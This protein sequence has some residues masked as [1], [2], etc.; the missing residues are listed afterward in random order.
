MAQDASKANMFATKR[1]YES[2]NAL[3]IVQMLN[4]VP[5]LISIYVRCGSD[6]Y[7]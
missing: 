6:V 4:L 3:V 5:E 2:H 7:Q 1:P